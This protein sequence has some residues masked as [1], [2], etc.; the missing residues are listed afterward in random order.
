VSRIADERR[1]NFKRYKDD[2]ETEGKPFFPYAMFHDTVMSLV[3]VSVIVALACIWYFT[4]D[5]D[6]PGEEGTGWLG[7]IYEHEADP[8]TTSFTPRP[9]WYFYF[10]FYL[11]RIFKWPDSV[12]LGT[13]GI[14]TIALMILIAMPFIDRRRERRLS[15][16]PVA[17]V[18]FLLTVAAMGILTYKGA[19][20][21][22]AAAAGEEVVDQ[23]ISDYGLPDDVRE[24]ATL[25]A[26]SQCL[27]CHVY[28]GEGASNLGAP[29]LTEIGSQSGKD[30][31]YLTRYI[32]DPS[33]FGNNVMPKFESLG[34]E[35]VRAIAEF[36]AASKGGG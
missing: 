1:E 13:V 23:W 7:V 32:A 2:V 17:V 15:R 12:V 10:L 28:G 16:R 11:L 4:G 22:E 14:P 19:T 9:D 26:Q 8:G 34:E 33:E 18:V 29:E 21:E 6:Q 3:V 5:P 25:F 36:L 30:A 20:A 24:G 31:D 35:R 27:N